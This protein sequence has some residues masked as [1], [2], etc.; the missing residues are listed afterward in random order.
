MYL[1]AEIRQ[2]GEDMG[3][4]G[5]RGGRWRPITVVL[6][7]SVALVGVGAVLASSHGADVGRAIAHTSVRKF[8]ALAVFAALFVP[9]ERLR[10]VVRQPALRRCW[11][12]DAV[13][14]LLNSFFATAGAIVIMLVLGVE[15]RALLPDRAHAAIAGQPFALQFVEALLL[16]ETAEYAAHRTMH[17]VP[18]LWRFHKVHHSVEDMDWLASARLHPVDRAFTNGAA[19]LPLFVFGFTDTTVGAFALF[20]AVHAM[21]VHA[22]VRVTFGPLRFLLTTPQYHHWHHAGEVWDK[23]FAAKLPL[24]DWLFRT[25]HVPARR[26]PKSYGVGEEAPEGY[27]EQLAWPFRELVQQREERVLDHAA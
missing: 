19:F 8:A 1:S 26:W 27:L 17:V 22:N 18:V 12:A 20:A 16:S 14:F 4:R 9:L 25:M 10:P 2:K 13:Y 5:R 24:V 11:R 21:F 6:G 23:N 15:F 7:V 3:G